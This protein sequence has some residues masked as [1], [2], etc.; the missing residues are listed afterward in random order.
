MGFCWERQ[1]E[2]DKEKDVDI[3]EDN[4]K[5]DIK[6]DWMGWLHQDRGVENTVMNL[7]IA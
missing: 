6:R 3:A 2:I 1:K 4:I 7:R 5:L